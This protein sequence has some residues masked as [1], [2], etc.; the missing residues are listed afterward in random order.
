MIN[1]LSK[2]N[3]CA[4]LKE[5]KRVGYYGSAVDVFLE[6]GNGP[7]TQDVIDEIDRE[8]RSGL[9]PHVRVWLE[10]VRAKFVEVSGE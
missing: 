2:P 6:W 3:V 1:D 5:S 4:L 10:G 8:L 9:K 7:D